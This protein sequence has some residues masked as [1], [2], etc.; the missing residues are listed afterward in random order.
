MECKQK[1]INNNVHSNIVNHENPEI[2][3]LTNTERLFLKRI[4]K[5]HIKG[6]KR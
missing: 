2:T 6:L 4:I 3:N 1:F 5:N